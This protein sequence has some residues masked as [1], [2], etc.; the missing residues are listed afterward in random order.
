MNKTLMRKMGLG[1][2]VDKVENSLCPF[3]NKKINVEDFRNEIS[4]REFGISGL[5]QKCQDN[6]FGV[7]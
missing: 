1:E 5:C 6:F 3:C 4:V 2:Y 7:D